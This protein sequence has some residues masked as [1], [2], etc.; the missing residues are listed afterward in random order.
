MLASLC[1]AGAP[2][3]IADRIGDGGAGTLKKV[4]TEAI[5]EHMAPIRARRAELEADPSYVDGVIRRGIERA[6]E[7]ANATLH[8][9]LESL[10]MSY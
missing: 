7:Q 4:A 6:N 5:N 10:Q 1:G 3:E 2:E 8:E 9:V